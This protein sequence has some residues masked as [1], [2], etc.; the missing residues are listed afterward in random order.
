MSDSVPILV[1]SGP[2][3]YSFGVASGW[4][5]MGD[6]GMITRSEGSLVYEIDGAPA[7]EFYHRFLGKD[8]KLSTDFPLIILN[9]AG[10]HEYIRPPSG[11]VSEE[12]RCG[13]CDANALG[14]RTVTSALPPQADVKTVGQLVC[15]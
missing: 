15:L 8:F 14:T 13:R 10:E 3:L 4:K 5:P 1:L 9:D 2:L 7:V 11:D 12:K 6:P